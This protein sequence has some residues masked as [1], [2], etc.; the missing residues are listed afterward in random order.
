MGGIL[1][2]N[3]RS[4]L[5]RNSVCD[6]QFNCEMWLYVKIWLNLEARTS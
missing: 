3:Y 4:Q 5:R 2:I 1:E 6:K